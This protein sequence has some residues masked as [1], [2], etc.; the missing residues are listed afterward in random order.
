M[1]DLLFILPKP[2]KPKWAVPAVRP[3]RDKLERFVM[4][5]L[6]SIVWT[7]DARVVG[8]L[9][10]KRYGDRPGVRITVWDPDRQGVLL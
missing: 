8:G 4:D 2:K 9:V 3:D 1:V 6:Q 10:E 7:D 5:A